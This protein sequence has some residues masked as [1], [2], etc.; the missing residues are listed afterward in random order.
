MSW[1]DRLKIL[2]RQEVMCQCGTMMRKYTVEKKDGTIVETNIHRC[3]FNEPIGLDGL[4][5]SKK[6]FV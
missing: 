3:A 1:S 6:K 5:I 4:V 2:A